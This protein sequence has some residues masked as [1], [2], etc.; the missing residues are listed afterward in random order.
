MEIKNIKGSLKYDNHKIQVADCKIRKQIDDYEKYYDGMFWN[1][2]YYDD[3]DYAE[4]CSNLL[5]K[6]ICMDRKFCTIAEYY[7]LDYDDFDYEIMLLD[8]LFN[9][10]HDEDESSCG[11]KYYILHLSLLDLLLDLEDREREL[12]LKELEAKLLMG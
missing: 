9:K 5:T 2:I 12:N 1:N 6:A 10:Y 8:M 11:E 4:L 7:K 3:F